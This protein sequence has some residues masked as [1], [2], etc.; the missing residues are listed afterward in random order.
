MAVQG[1]GLPALSAKPVRAIRSTPRRFSG[2]RASVSSRRYSQRGAQPTQMNRR[3]VSGLTD[4]FVSVHAD[5]EAREKEDIE[6]TKRTLESL[7]F[8]SN[9][10]T[11]KLDEWKKEGLNTTEKVK[12]KLVGDA[13]RALAARFA[14]LGLNGWLIWQT[15]LFSLAYQAEDSWL[16]W[17]FKIFTYF[18]TFSFVQEAILFGVV[19]YA[20]AQFARN[21]VLLEAMQEIAGVA[22]LP[23]L[24]VKPQKV[25]DSIK[26]FKSLLELNSRLQAMEYK[27]SSLDTLSSLLTLSQLDYDESVDMS[28]LDTAAKVFNRYDTN[29]DQKLDSEEFRLMLQDAG[30]ALDEAEIQ[31]AIKILDVVKVDGYIQ[32]DEFVAFWAKKMEKPDEASRVEK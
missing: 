9:R 5:E 6:N 24:E 8:D 26:V 19:A 28:S 1:S 32:F 21:P 15:Y 7:G 11:M 29:G 12:G 13:A 10:A 31:E 16:Q 23:A 27:S 22:K 25:V 17:P 4:R 18:N 2:E 14:W 3:P 30:L 20:T